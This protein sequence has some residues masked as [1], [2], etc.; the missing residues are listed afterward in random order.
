M[1]TTPDS[2]LIKRAATAS[3]AT[4]TIL[5]LAKVFAWSISDSSSVLSSLL[6]SLMDIA[7]S[8][9]NYFAI[10]YALMPADDDHPFGHTK[11][12]GLAA[13][14]QSAFILGSATFLL[15]HVVD[16]LLHPQALTSLDESIAVMVF[17][18]IMTSLLVAY[19][20][21][22]YRKTR[23]LAIK[24]DSAHYYGDILTSAA[25]VVALLAAYWDVNWLDPVVALGIALVLLYSVYGI[26]RDALEVL[27]DKA[28]PEDEEEELKALISACPG[29]RGFHDMKTRQ[30][31]AIQFI[32]IHLD[33]DGDQPLRSAHAIGNEVERAILARFPRAE[34]IVHHDPV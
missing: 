7:A 20:R 1:T 18:V 34:I 32:Q 22:V 12:E 3:I 23:S 29:V 33:L 14:I 25:V 30:A 5:L 10:R 28:M 9:V 15:L 6:D 31:G 11:A 13:L 8:V 17:S 2:V 4:A 21:W 24:A 26:V 16:R 27:M 19:Q